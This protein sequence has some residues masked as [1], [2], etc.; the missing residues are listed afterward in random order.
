M[1]FKFTLL[2]FFTQQLLLTLQHFKSSNKLEICFVQ[3]LVA[4]WKNS[5]FPKTYHCHCVTLTLTVITWLRQCFPTIKLLFIF[6]SILYFL[7]V[8]YYVQ[9]HFWSVVARSPYCYRNIISQLTEQRNIWICID[10]CNKICVNVS[11]CHHHIYF[12]LSMAS[13]SYL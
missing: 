5:L 3:F 13:Y 6:L 2:I 7:K 1:I 8:S 10:L 4:I 12:K 9:E 11:L